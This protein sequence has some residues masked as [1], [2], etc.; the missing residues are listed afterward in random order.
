MDN[1]LQNIFNTAQ[2]VRLSSVEKA[3]MRAGLVLFTEKHPVR[4]IAVA[5]QLMRE[6]SKPDILAFAEM[7][8]LQSLLSRL[9]P[10]FIALLIALLVGGGTSFAAGSALPGDVLYPVKIGVNEEVGSF[11]AFSDEA[12]ARF[13]ARRAENRLEEAEKLAAKGRLDAEASAQIESRFESH[14]KAFEEGVAAVAA[15]K[16]SPSSFEMH[17]NFEASLGAHEQVLAR[18]ALERSEARLVLEP[19]LISVRTRLEATERARVSAETDV[20]AQANGEFKTAAEGKMRAAENKIREVRSF[21]ER[22]KASISAGAYAAAEARLGVAADVI[23]RGK[24][25]MEAETYGSAFAS[26]QEAIRIAQEVQVLTAVEDRIDIEIEVPG[27][28]L[29]IKTGD[30][31]EDEA[32]VEGAG[33]AEEGATQGTSSRAFIELESETKLESETDSKKIEGEGKIKIDVGL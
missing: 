20:R 23:A 27:I 30:A 25:E 10:M 5:R 9:Q 18:L 7:S 21:L 32:R 15:K 28:D 31:L 24:A 12:Q 11:L 16:N 17:S 19:L 33:E 6:R 3:E 1:D 2:H 13:D 22:K 4:N 14:T 26:L 29:K 8:A